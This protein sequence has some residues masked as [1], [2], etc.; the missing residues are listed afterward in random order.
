MR[1][2]IVGSRHL[3]G[4]YSGVERGLQQFLPFLVQRGHSVTVFGG[5]MPDTS[6]VP[7]GY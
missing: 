3:L 5:A 4:G 1:I 7:N 2:A 6:N